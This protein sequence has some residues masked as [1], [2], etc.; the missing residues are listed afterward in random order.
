MNDEFNDLPVDLGSDL[1]A[2]DWAELADVPHHLDRLPDGI[3]TLVFGDPEGCKDFN[4]QQGDNDLGFRNDC[5]LV[6]CEDVLRQ[7]G[8]LVT[9]NDL[10]H[11]A[12]DHGECTW[13]KDHPEVSGLTTVEE[14]ME[15][16]TDYGI[17]ARTEPG[18]SLE[19]LASQVEH[20][21]GVIAC[22]NAGYLWN[23]QDFVESG[24]H[25]HNI[26]VTGVA[27]DPDTN[28]IQGFFIND[29]GTGESGKF[30]TEETM[31]KAWLLHGFGVSVVTE[32][33]LPYNPA[34]KP[35]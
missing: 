8:C 7:F 15:I 33:S 24:Q 35:L 9:E 1:S 34:A 31:E 32:A 6:A 16:L 25:N 17:P 5:G 21:H 10:V 19:D 28:Q 14:K 3:E 29:S 22:V 4:H 30:V 13:I 23:D 18:I 26:T 2:R 12:V 11:H 27:R 20:G